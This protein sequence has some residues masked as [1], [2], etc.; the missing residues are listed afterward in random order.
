MHFS[1]RRGGLATE[2]NQS[3]MQISVG[4]LE[5]VLNIDIYGP[6]IPTST[7]G[8]VRSTALATRTTGT[9][10]V[11]RRYYTNILVKRT[12][13]ASLALCIE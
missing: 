5:R 2:I 6:V 11:R 13:K 10:A 8:Q 1:S 12:S 9:S 7:S 4:I 3:G